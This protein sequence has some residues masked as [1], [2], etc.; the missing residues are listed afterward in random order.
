MY[1]ELAT[2]GS[3]VHVSVLCPG[4]VRTKIADSR[5]N[6]PERLGTAPDMPDDQMAQMFEAMLR[7]LVEGGVEPEAVAED[8]S[9]A[10]QEERFWILPNA[11]SYGPVIKEV[12]ASA[13]EGRTPPMLVPA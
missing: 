8:V 4:M 5:R 13:V 3:H 11:E 9:R 10:V 7:S 12:A 1:Q 6:W 2:L